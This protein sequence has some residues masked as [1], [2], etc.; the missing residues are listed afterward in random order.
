MDQELSLYARKMLT[1]IE[2]NGGKKERRDILGMVPKHVLPV[3]VRELV[4]KDLITKH[5][6][7]RYGYNRI[8]YRLREA[9]V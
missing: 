9:G 8:E 2:R 7:R 3:V 1:S 6:V 5:R 4:E